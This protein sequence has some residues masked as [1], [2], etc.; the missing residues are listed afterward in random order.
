M[1]NR[2]AFS[3]LLAGA[4][5]AAAAPRTAWSQSVSKKTVFYAS[6]GPELALHDVDVADAA[7]QKRSAVTLP[8]NIQ[9]VWP[10]PSRQYLYVVSS[11]GGPGLI[12]GDKHL[13]NAFKID[14]ASGALTPHGE[15]QPLPSRPIHCCVDGAGEYL[16][17]AFNHPSNVTVHRIN[18]DGTL[19]SPVEQTGKPDAGIFGHQVLTTPGNQSAIFVAR[20][21][22][23]EATKPEDPG[24]LKVFGFKDG[25]LSNRASVAP[26]NGYGFGP[27]HLDFHPR[28]P[29]VFVSVERQSQL[30]VYKLTP[31]HSLAPD[32]L[33]VK[34]SLAEPG[35]VRRAQAAGAIHVHP[36]GRFVYLT[37]R[38][39]GTV[40]FE[41]QKVSGGGENNVAVF[42]IDQ[43]TGEPKLIQNADAHTVHLRTFGI[44][45]SGRLLVAASI[46]PMAVREGGGVKTVPAAVSVYRIGDDGKLTFARKYD[47]DTG[48]VMQFWSGMV[49][50][51]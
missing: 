44:D 8:A 33:F 10:H 39:S 6:V 9:Y 5:G 22:N 36:N 12:P 43:A 1:I 3:A 4:A 45:P 38:N 41:G 18:R 21:N 49:A 16:L 15:P 26:G 37:N 19:G 25:V 2:R 7:L 24:A 50:L 13:A 47:V 32:P 31:D 28:Q 40:D 35:N 42:S 27:R 20:G 11:N 51:G 46:L 14:P 30:H 17:T 29:W 23:A 48:K 34:S